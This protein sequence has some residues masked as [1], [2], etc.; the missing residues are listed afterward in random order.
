MDEKLVRRRIS[1]RKRTLEGFCKKKNAKRTVIRINVPLSNYDPDEVLFY[2]SMLFECSPLS[3][4]QTFCQRRFN[5]LLRVYILA[6]KQL[7]A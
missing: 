1:V 5:A 4:L 2:K 7:F 3:R 6:K